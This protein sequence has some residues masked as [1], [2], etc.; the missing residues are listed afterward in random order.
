MAPSNIWVRLQQCSSMNTKA[1]L[2][3]VTYILC[4]PHE[5]NLYFVSDLTLIR[6][7]FTVLNLFTYLSVLRSAH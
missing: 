2:T 4:G 5:S 7:Y 6:P 3:V 1:S